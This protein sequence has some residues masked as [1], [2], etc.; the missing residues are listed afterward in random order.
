MK[1]LPRPIDLINRS[2]GLSG[3]TPVRGLAYGAAPR[4]ILDVFTPP[5]QTTPAPVLVFFYGGSWQSG[6]R[7]D[8]SF[9]AGLFAARGFV[10][11]LPDYRIFPDVRYPAFIEDC[12]ASLDWV[13]SHIANYGGDPKTVFVMGHS[14]GAYNAMMA[15]LMAESSDIAGVIGLAGPYDF[16]PLKDP[17]IK[18]IF[19]SVSDLHET[20]PITHIRVG[21]PP[22]FLATGGA[23]RVVLPRNSTALAARI[24]HVGGVVET[25]IYPKRGHI[26]LF[27]AL[28]PYLAWRAP[29]MA[30]VLDFIAAC[31]A[32][33][34]T[35]AGAEFSAPMVPKPL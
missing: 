33:D 35:L 21:L 14:A 2:I 24:R 18:T 12:A 16:L 20:Q 4:Q 30:D 26:G 31:R 5:G 1:F 8:Y 23:D 3:A 13:S 11:V 6:S 32:G 34:F 17:A 27:L 25:R 10:V 19:S 29:V 9:I 7:T 28:L 15:V 22:I